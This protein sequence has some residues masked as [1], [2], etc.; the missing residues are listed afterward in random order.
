MSTTDVLTD[1]LEL[2]LEANKL[3]KVQA[4]ARQKVFKKMR[5]T[6]KLVK[7]ETKDN[8]LEKQQHLD[9]LND[10]IEDLDFKFEQRDHLLR[11]LAQSDVNITSR[12]ELLTIITE[13]ADMEE[14]SIYK[15]VANY[16]EVQEIQGK[17]KKELDLLETLSSND[18][19]VK[20]VE[21]VRKR[22]EGMSITQ[23]SFL[24]GTSQYQATKIIKQL[25][26]LG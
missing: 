24:L 12:N 1:T 4:L 17:I 10:R 23:L 21:I 22:P 15:M 5:T 9:K 2:L 26:D 7:F 3:L 6:S 25:V 16:S 20:A 19:R 14:A 8:N 11:E 13:Y 18:P